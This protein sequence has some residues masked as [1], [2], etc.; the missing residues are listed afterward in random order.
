MTFGYPISLELSGRRAVV[1]GTVAVALGKAEGLTR[2]GAEVTVIARQPAE[3]LEDLELGGAIVHR[4]DYR[5]GDLEGAAIAI[6]S[7]P[8]DDVRDAIVEEA[9]RRHVLLNMID[10]IPRS[11]WAAPATVRRGDLVIAISTGGRSPSLARRLREQLESQFGPEWEQA[12]E[13]LESVRHETLPALPHFEERARRWSE[14]LDTDELLRLLEAGRGDEA[15]ARLV[16][17][18]VGA[19]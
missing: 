15:R 18:L 3:L 1:I 11:D 14:A 5:D 19:R 2:A 17:R 6:A 8:S 13:L 9:R 10:D 4:R 16:K 12:L 7:D